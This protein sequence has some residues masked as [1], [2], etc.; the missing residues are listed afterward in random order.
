MLF[1]KP[2]CTSD[3]FVHNVIRTGG[4]F[5]GYAVLCRLSLEQSISESRGGRTG[6]S[7]A[8]LLGDVHVLGYQR[9]PA[10]LAWSDWGLRKALAIAALV[11]TPELVMVNGDALDEGNSCN[12]D[13]FRLSSTRFRS[14]MAVTGAGEGSGKL[15]L[16]RT[17]GNHD[18]GLGWEV[19][20][21]LVVHSSH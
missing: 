11:H 8:L 12:D 9:H 3:D 19:S 13:E 14:I 18:V 4:W 20:W 1:S 10:D 16:L 21:C 15:P 7:R 2:K 17:V 6:W 5:L